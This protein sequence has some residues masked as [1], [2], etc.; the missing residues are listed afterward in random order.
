MTL[1]TLLVILAESSFMGIGY[2]YIITFLVGLI[3][4]MLCMVMMLSGGSGMR[5]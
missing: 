5:R 4:G 2:S 1:A 3:L